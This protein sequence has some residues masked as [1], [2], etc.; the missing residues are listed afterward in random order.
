VGANWD[1]GGWLE[2]NTTNG[3]ISIGGSGN[4]AK[5]KAA[6]WRITVLED[7]QRKLP[8]IIAEV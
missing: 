7:D 8:Q 5:K 4:E 6:M 2:V 3:T 1:K